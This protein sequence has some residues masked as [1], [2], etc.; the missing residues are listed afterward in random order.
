VSYPAWQAA[1]DLLACLQ[2][3]AAGH[4]NPVLSLLGPERQLL[5]GRKYPQPPLGFGGGRWRAYYHYHDGQP[6]APGEHGHFHIFVRAPKA[7]AS[8]GREARWAHLAGLG[9]DGLG[10]PLRWFAVNAWVTDDA[11]LPR[12]WLL[13]QLQELAPDDDAGLLPAWLGAMLGLYRDELDGLLADRDQ[14]L[15]AAGGATVL[16]L[17]DRSLY[18][19]AERPVDLQDRLEAVLNSAPLAG[20]Q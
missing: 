7:Q 5:S 9:M 19:L 1:G 2:A 18:Q 10:Q 14:A 12:D 20:H 13:A 8:H 15:A 6:L 16:R 4:G 11:W 3:F 17:A